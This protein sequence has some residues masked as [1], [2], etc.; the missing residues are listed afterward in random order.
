MDEG[1]R[2]RMAMAFF[3]TQAVF[4]GLAVFGLIFASSVW[5]SWVALGLALGACCAV[6]FSHSAAHTALVQ[7]LVG[8]R[9]QIS[10]RAM[11]VSKWLWYLAV[12]LAILSFV[13]LL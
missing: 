2:F 8:L 10:P 6:L 1:K 9:S 4:G 12:G 3:W 7:S 5:G 13:A 11:A